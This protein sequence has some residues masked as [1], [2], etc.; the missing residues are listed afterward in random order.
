MCARVFVQALRHGPQR[1]QQ[2][3]AASGISCLQQKD[4]HQ[5]VQI[6]ASEDSQQSQVSL[7]VHLCVVFEFLYMR[8]EMCA[9]MCEGTQPY[10]E[11]VVYV[12]KCVCAGVVGTSSLQPSA[13]DADSA[14]LWA[15]QWSEGKRAAAAAAQNAT[16]S[17]AGAT[18][19]TAGQ[20]ADQKQR[21]VQKPADKKQ[22]P[23]DQKH[24]KPAQSQ[25]A[26]AKRTEIADAVGD[27]G[28]CGSSCSPRGAALCV[29]ACSADVHS[30]VVLS[31]RAY[32]CVCVYVCMCVNAGATASTAGQ[33]AD[34]KQRPVQK[35]AD[36]KQQPADQKHQKPAQ[37]QSAKAK[38]TEIADAVGDVGGCGSS[39]SPRGAAL[40]VVACSAD[41]H[42]LVVLS[43]RAY[44]CVCVYVCM[45]V[46]AGA[47][48]STAGHPQHPQ[49][50]EPP[51]ASRPR[52]S[53]SPLER[54]AM[55][56]LIEGTFDIVL[57]MCTVRI[58]F[59]D[60]Y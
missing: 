36:K 19:S 17:T 52:I 8:G 54:S 11:L 13:S 14:K 1:L 5:I 55:W 34:Q 45:C 25:S 43:V 53:Y 33:P 16:A 37:S 9:C 3:N 6:Q 2:T 28:G 24:Q 51:R 20:P 56:A 41:V 15:K 10:T 35:P 49:H 50:D 38:R 18:A 44:V 59:I 58:M 46:N 26:K 12:C 29:V 40:C 22:Q 27:V 21:P 31:V 7:W 60:V 39:C 23:A 48:A 32:V 57:Q 42:S 4:A 30:L 47:S